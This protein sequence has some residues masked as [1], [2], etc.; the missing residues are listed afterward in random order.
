MAWSTNSGADGGY[1]VPKQIDKQIDAVAA[2]Q[3]AM[4]GLVRVVD[5]FTNDYHVVVQNTRNAN[6]WVGETAARPATNTGQFVDVKPPMGEL[7]A[8]PQLTRQLIDD[9]GFNVEQYVTDRVGEEFGVAI[10]TAILSG[11][12]TNQP[13]GILSATFASTDD[14]SRTF[15]QLQY[16]PTGVAGGWPATNPADVLL[17]LIYKTKAAY[18]KNSSFVMHP[19]LMQEIMAFKDSTGRYLIQPG[20]SQGE[21]PTLFGYPIFESEMMPTKAAS[22]LSILFGDFS[23][24]YVFVNRTPT[25]MIRDELTNKPYVGLYTTRRVAGAVTNSEAV[26]ALKFSVS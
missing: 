25:R 23:R 7:Y 4:L 22:S 15:G 6:S 13:T 5:S 26:K 24:A 20:I 3:G 10:E 12:G 9:A 8:N 19:L 21:P 17:T 18:R 16:I 1:A 2:Q 11:T 14:T